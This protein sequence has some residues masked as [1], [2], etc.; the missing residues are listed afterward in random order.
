MH[1][2]NSRKTICC[3]IRNAYLLISVTD[4]D[5]RKITIERQRTERLRKFA[6]VKVKLNDVKGK[7]PLRKQGKRKRATGL[8]GTTKC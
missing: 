3:G 1:G 5:L 8:T 6:D 2:S 4:K 7:Q